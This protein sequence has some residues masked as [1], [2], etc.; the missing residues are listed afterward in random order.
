MIIKIRGDI[1][2]KKLKYRHFVKIN[3]N[4]MYKE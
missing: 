4:N 3:N 2:N 1:D